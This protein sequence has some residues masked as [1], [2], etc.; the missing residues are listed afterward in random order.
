MTNEYEVASVIELGQA[1][2]VVLGEK[3]VAQDVDSLTNEPGMRYI[4]ATD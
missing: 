1:K 4:V 3:V 2:D